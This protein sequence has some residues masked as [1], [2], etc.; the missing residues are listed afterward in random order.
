MSDVGGSKLSRRGCISRSSPWG[1]VY[2][3]L[4]HSAV[5]LPLSDILTFLRRETMEGNVCDEKVPFGDP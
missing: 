5:A 1:S 3:A 4:P 2:P